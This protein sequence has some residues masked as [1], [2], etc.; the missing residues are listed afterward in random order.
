M[1]QLPS[2]LTQKMRHRIG[3]SHAPVFSTLC[4]AFLCLYEQVLFV[5]R[6]LDELHSHI[7][8]IL[9]NAKCIK[10]KMN[11]HEL[12]ISALTLKG[13][14]LEALKHAKSVLDSLGFPFPPSINSETVAGIVTSLGSTTMAFTPDKLRAFPLMTEKVPLQAMRIMRAVHMPFSFSHPTMFQM[15]ACQMVQLTL[16][17]G[18]CVESAEAFANFGY[19]QNTLF[20]NFEIGFR[21]GKLALIILE[22]FKATHNVA[23]VYFLVHGFLSVW[24]EPLQ[25][26]I[27]GL[28]SS[29]NI[30]LLEGDFQNAMFNQ[31]VLNRQ[32]ILAGCHLSECSESLFAICREFVRIFE[33]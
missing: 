28:R 6:S 20:H 16:K 19:V 33:S 3:L 27:E 1:V 25:A 9:K 21:M 5:K 7:D 13:S 22:R 24:R 31:V 29:V 17:H 26:T 11:A 14:N 12:L 15:M 30:G 10:D 4:C 32:M 23:K 18:I 8:I 2:Q